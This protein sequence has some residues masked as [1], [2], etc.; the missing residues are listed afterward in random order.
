[1]FEIQYYYFNS[2][3]II[4]FQLLIENTWAASWTAKLPLSGQIQVALAGNHSLQAVKLGFNLSSDSSNP[5]VHPKSTLLNPTEYYIWCLWTKLQMYFKSQLLIKQGRGLTRFFALILALGMPMWLA[6]CQTHVSGTLVILMGHPAVSW[7]SKTW[8]WEQ[9]SQCRHM[10]AI[11]VRP[12]LAAGQLMSQTWREAPSPP[13]VGTDPQPPVSSLL[14][15]NMRRKCTS[16]LSIK[17][18]I[19]TDR[20]NREAKYFFVWK[21]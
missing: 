6:L 15:N 10:W 16:R 20:G 21:I 4:L 3:I 17:R 7:T 13:G 18:E 2:I 12:S 5:K 1:M 9:T 14:S 11:I 8:V 19:K